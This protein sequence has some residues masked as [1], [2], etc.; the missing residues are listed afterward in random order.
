MKLL[1][2]HKEFSGLAVKGFL[3]GKDM[4]LLIC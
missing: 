3:F 4:P 1:D 2:W